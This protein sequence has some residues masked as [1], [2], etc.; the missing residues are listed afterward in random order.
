MTYKEWMNEVDGYLLS[1]CGLTSG[2][3][4]DG[5]SRDSYD[6]GDSPEEYADGLLE[7]E[8]YPMEDE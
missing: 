4:A 2:D 7:D 8:G 5:P 3:L 1:K 6:S